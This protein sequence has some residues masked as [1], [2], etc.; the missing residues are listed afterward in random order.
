[1][2]GLVRPGHVCDWAAGIA[3]LAAGLCPTLSSL[4]GAVVGALLAVATAP[5]LSSG[6]RDALQHVGE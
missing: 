5:R 2:S 6:D 1:M 3:T 4:G